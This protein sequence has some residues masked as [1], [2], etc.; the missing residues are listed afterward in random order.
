M[1]IIGSPER[2]VSVF[3]KKKEIILQARECSFIR[4]GFGLMFKTRKTDNLLFSFDRPSSLSLT[5]LFVF[6]PFLVLWL[7]KKNNVI[8]WTLV[9]SF[10]STIKTEKKFI[11]ILEL[12]LNRENSK[13]IDFFVDKRKI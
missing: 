9:R 5:G 10:T 8:D 2:I 13:I 11:K 1:Q 3:Y 12:P 6:F 7:D 4:K